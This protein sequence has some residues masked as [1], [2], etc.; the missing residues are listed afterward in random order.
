MLHG[1]DIVITHVIY[2]RLVHMVKDG[3][4]DDYDII[5]DEVSE[6]VKV[7]TSKSKTSI[8][9]FYIDAGYL[10]VDSATGLVR[11]TMKWCNYR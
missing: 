3:F 7:V 9:K 4:A 6:V 2:E 10:N 1:Q 8:Q 5:I 11:P